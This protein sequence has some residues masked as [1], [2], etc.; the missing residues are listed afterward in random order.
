MTDYGLA[1]ASTEPPSYEKDPSDTN[2]YSMSWHNLG[3]DSI[4]TA[5]WTSD[6]FDVGASTVSGLVTTCFV[7]GGTDGAIHSLTCTVTTAMGRT[8]QRTTY[9]AVSQL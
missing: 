9:I 1:I 4:L 6:G 2:A 3:S 5:T 8:V 7:S